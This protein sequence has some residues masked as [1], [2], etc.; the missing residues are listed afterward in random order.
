CITAY[1][2]RKERGDLDTLLEFTQSVDEGIPAGLDFELD[3]Q[4]IVRAMLNL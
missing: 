3:L 2:W 1:L 4:T